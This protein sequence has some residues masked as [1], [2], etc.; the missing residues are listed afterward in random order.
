MANSRRRLQVL[1]G[2]KAT[3]KKATPK[4]KVVKKDK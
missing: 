4:K 3:T 1:S 2:K